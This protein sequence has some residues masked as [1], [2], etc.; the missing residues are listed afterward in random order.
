MRA[1]HPQTKFASD[2][3]ALYM[4]IDKIYK[5]FIFVDFTGV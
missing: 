2:S 5:N 1:T 3:P 4:Y